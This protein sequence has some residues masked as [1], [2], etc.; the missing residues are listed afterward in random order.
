MIQIF[1]SAKH[2]FYKIARSYPLQKI[3][4]QHYV[5]WVERLF[6]NDT[7]QFQ[8][9]MLRKWIQPFSRSCLLSVEWIRFYIFLLDRIYRIDW[10]VRPA[11]V[12]GTRFE[13][14]QK[15]LIPRLLQG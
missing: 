4:M 15:Q 13:A 8:D 7:H 5:D 9:V 6:K 1:D 11:V 3:E 10:I 12:G 14:K 2:V